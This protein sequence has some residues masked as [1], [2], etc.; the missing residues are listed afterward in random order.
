MPR[1]VLALPILA[2]G[3]TACTGSTDPATGTVFDNFRNLQSGEFDRQI[4]AKQAQARSIEAANARSQARINSL[5]R[6][7]TSNASAISGLR[8]EVSALR[9]QISAAR[10]A[11]AGNPTRQ[12][13]L[14]ALNSQVNA[15]NSELANGGDASIARS[16]LRRIRSAVAA[17]SS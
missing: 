2:L 17:L 10:S 11:N 3:L 5:E 12:A 16:E 7:R 13:Q 8:G 9:A 1:L 15:V 14:A 4:S 6:Q